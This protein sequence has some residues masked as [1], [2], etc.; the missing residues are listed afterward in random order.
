[1]RINQTNQWDAFLIPRNI[2]AKWAVKILVKR[3][4]LIWSDL[5]RQHSLRRSRVRG[6]FPDWPQIHSAH[7]LIPLNLRQRILGD[8]RQERIDRAQK[9]QHRDRFSAV[10][11]T[12]PV[13]SL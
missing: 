7:S 10:C 2:G 9:A 6:Y 12:T 4:T 1:M 11:V 3:I 8:S 5:V 13:E